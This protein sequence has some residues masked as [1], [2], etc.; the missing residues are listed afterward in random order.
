MA[1]P[2]AR[3]CCGSRAAALLTARRASGTR[4]GCVCPSVVLYF[5]VVFKEVLD[6]ELADVE[7]V[8]HNGLLENLVVVLTLSRERTN[9]VP[10]SGP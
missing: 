7:T 2:G 5:V 8:A 1:P 6:L 3:R 4:R 9:Q 10:S